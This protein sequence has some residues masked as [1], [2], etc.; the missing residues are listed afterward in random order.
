LQDGGGGDCFIPE[1]ICFGGGG[2]KEEGKCDSRKRKKGKSFALNGRKKR[3]DRQNSG[4]E[5]SLVYSFYGIIM[6]REKK[7]LSK[8]KRGKCNEKHR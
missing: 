1:R 6:E 7:T 8:K 2:G 3:G 5:D 4:G